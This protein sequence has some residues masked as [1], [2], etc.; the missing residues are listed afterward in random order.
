MSIHPLDDQ[1]ISQI[2]AGEVVERP[3][4]VVKELVENSLDADATNIRIE[5]EQGG[6]RYIG[7]ADDGR[8]ISADELRL[9]L[10][11]HATSKIDSLATLEAAPYLGFRGEALASIASV[12]SLRLSARSV[13]AGHG[14][15]VDASTPGDIRPAALEQ[16]TRCEVFELFSQV[17][18]RRKFL[19]TA[20]TEF[21]HIQRVFNQLALSR[22]DV[23]FSLI[24]DNTCRVA[25]PPATER[26]AIVERIGKVVGTGFVE[27]AIA[28][29]EA[30]DGMRLSGWLATPGLSR[31]RAD[32]QYCFVNERPVR[33]PVIN[34]AVREAYR[35]LLHS[36]RYPAF[37]LYLEIDAA[38]IDVNAHPAKSEIRFRQ[39]RPTHEF[40]RRSVARAL[41]ANETQSTGAH[42]TDLPV[43]ESPA[44]R[45]GDTATNQSHAAISAP[46]EASVAGYPDKAYTSQYQFQMPAEPLGVQEVP[47][48]QPDTAPA[49][50]S[51]TLGHA[52]GQIHDIFILAENEQG[53][54]VVDMHAAHERVL[55][56]QLKTNHARGALA[57]SRLL[58]PAALDLEPGGAEALEA[59]QDTVAHL[60]FEITPSAPDKARITAIPELLTERDYI[61]LAGD[62]V[63]QLIGENTS[64]ETTGD[65]ADAHIRGVVDGVLADIGCKAAVK[66]GHRLTITEMNQLLQDMAHTHHAGHCN[67]GRPSWIQVDR[68]GLD[69]LFMRGQ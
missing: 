10:A 50:G 51:D 29:D 6:L 48:T 11:R 49:G 14:S 3:A 58:V 20:A 23:G 67:H 12:A 19:K 42:T 52:L 8:G 34:H 39:S 30:V 18:A 38:A 44:H 69:R 62:L 66:A 33:D 59:Y 36:Q 1:L 22:F 46:R 5:I 31:A 4:S 41:A 26:Q 17:P 35:D 57:S 53:L 32:L 45:P 55:Y 56:E 47:D 65:G 13:E 68:A 60:G 16:G 25:L 43:V 63:A 54:I 27:H 21:R 9:A 24:H 15:V 61:G 2:A 40:V 7:V 28:L 64:G 37:I